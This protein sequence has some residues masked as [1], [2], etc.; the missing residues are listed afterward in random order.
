MSFYDTIEIGIP[1]NKVRVPRIGL[2]T[3]GMS[4]IY[5][6]VDDNQSVDVLNY[7]I[8]I[9]SGNVEKFSELI[10]GVDGSP[11]YVRKCIENSLTRLGVDVFD[12]YYQHRMDP[13][14]SIEETVK[15]MAELVKEG[16]VRYIGLSECTPDILRKAH[17]VHPITT[18]Q[19]EYSPWSVHIE[20]D[21]ILDTCRELGITVVAYSSLGRGIM[22]GK[23]RSLDG[24][25][26][27]DWRRK[28]PRFTKEHFE[29]NLKLVDAFDSLTKKHGCTSGQLALAWL[30]T[31][32]KNL[33]LVPGTRKIKC[34]DESFGANHI[35]TD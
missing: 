20:T 26:E 5:G 7:A 14:A 4:P 21:G 8:D 1:G 31:Q 28:N 6:K 23:I 2:G 25:D 10:T 33:V 16:K 13:S 24:L 34:L 35:K 30:L 19:I 12:L 32:E 11:E 22:T 15:V 3:M 9:G 29:Q 27:N 18:V 17:K